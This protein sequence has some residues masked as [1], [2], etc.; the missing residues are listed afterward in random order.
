MKS[1]ICIEGIAA[2]TAKAVCVNAIVSFNANKTST[3]KVWMPRSVVA[4]ATEKLI[5]VEEWFLSKLS[6]QNAFHGYRMNFERPIA[7]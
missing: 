4:N 3:R 7:L 5:E 6:E 2:E 1:L